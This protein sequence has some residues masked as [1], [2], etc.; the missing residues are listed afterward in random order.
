MHSS[1][2][3][4]DVGDVGVLHVCAGR[5]GCDSRVEVDDQLVQQRLLAGLKPAAV[6]DHHEPCGAHRVKQQPAQLPHEPWLV[7]ER[8]RVRLGGEV[9]EGGAERERQAA[10]G[11]REVDRSATQVRSG[12]DG[13]DEGTLT[14][15]A[16]R[17]VSAYAAS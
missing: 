5:G 8:R 7:L 13:S 11:Q 1:W 10:P 6:D 15:P 3:F 17:A 12:V 2:R 16:G 9:V 14:N 4:E